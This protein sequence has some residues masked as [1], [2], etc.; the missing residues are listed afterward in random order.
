ME[1][2]PRQTRVLAQKE[3]IPLAGHD[4]GGILAPVLQDQQGI[5]KGLVDRT[6]TDDTDDTAHEPPR[7][8]DK[9]APMAAE[10]EPYG[11]ACRA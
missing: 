3:L 10:G 6:L 4:A 9:G 11:R 7:G 5:V 2:I 8:W 1:D